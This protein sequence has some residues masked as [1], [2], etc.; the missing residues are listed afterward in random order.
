VIPLVARAF[1][2]RGL[3]EALS[4]RASFVLQLFGAALSLAAF[5]YFARFVDAAAPTLL[6]GQG[7][8]YLSYGL[9]G[10]VALNLQHAMIS[11]YPQVVREAQLAGTL[12]AL[13]ATPTPA[14]VVL[15]CAPIYRVA[16]ALT[17]AAVLLVAGALLFG[18]RFG[19]ANGAA[20]LVCVPLSLVSF[21]ALGLIGASL[22]MLMRRPDPLSLMIG[23]VSVLASGVFYPTAM[24][25]P[26]LQRVGAVL[27]M[28]HALALVRR[29]TFAGAGL[30]TLGPA[31][32]GLGIFCAVALPAGLLGFTWALRRTRRDGSL[33]HY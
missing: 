7:G 21:A 19:G 15:L 6:R 3:Q 30:R 27:P 12:E 18:V 23:G 14:W 33:S 29:A 9:V 31:L 28:T 20:L 13:L 26:W 10:L 16:S 24:L 17:S 32:L 4:Y 8:D 11:A 5:F 22:T 1:F 25:P 2:R